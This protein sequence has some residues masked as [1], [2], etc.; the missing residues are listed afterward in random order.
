[1]CNP[2]E[3][4]TTTVT[5]MLAIGITVTTAPI[6]TSEFT[7][8]SFAAALPRVNHWKPAVSAI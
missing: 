6:A 5:I 2:L 3:P 4:F 1:M 8:A 7:K